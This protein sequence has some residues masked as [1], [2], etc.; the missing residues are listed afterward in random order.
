MSDTKEWTISINSFGGFIP[1][2]F[3]NSYP[4]Y[5]NKEM[6]SDMENIDLTDPNVM[7]QGPAPNDLINGDQTGAVTTVIR[8]FLRSVVSDGVSYAIG[9][10]KLQKISST[11]VTNTGGVFPHTITHDGSEDGEDLVYYQSKLYYFYNQAGAVGDIGQLTFPST[12]E[13]DWG[14][15]HA[16]GAAALQSAPHQAIIGGDDVVA[17]TNGIY[18]GTIDGTTL[19]V[20]ALDFWVDSVAV[21]ITWN[22]NRYK[23]AVNRPNVAG[24]N[25]NQSGIYTW[26]GTSGS[27]EGDPVEVNGKIGALYTK[28][29]ITFVWWQDSGTSNEFNFGYL[30]GTQLK[31]LKRCEGTLPL[32][33]QVGEHKGFIAFISDGLVY[34][35]GSADPDLPVIFFQYTSS[36]YTTTIGGIGTPFGD[37]LTSSHNATTGYSLAKASGYTIDSTYKLKAFDMSAPGYVSVMDKIQ[38]TTEQLSTGAKVDS[39][40]TYDKAKSTQTLTQIAYSTAN[41]TLHKILNKSYKLEDFRLDFDFAN[42]SITNP[43]KIRSILIKGHYVPES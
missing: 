19:N 37:L 16:T 27:W 39:T 15:A 17:F 23:I 14:S 2:W 11:T 9:G 31:V 3:K 42:G 34:L 20:D 10:N 21:S 29:G 25:L 26:D 32:F 22:E 6:A 35:W 30:S 18:V 13:D 43:V 24:A 36:L 8:S 1:A 38:I 5:G 40:L 28:N 4:F 7:T 12:F 33:Y 41:Y